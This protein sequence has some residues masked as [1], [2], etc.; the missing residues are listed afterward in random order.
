M[1]LGGQPPFFLCL[2]PFSQL[3]A[4]RRDPVFHFRNWAGQGC[5]GVQTASLICGIG[6]LALAAL[7]ATQK[8]SFVDHE[9]GPVKFFH[10]KSVDEAKNG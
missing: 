10:K 5:A 8:Q 6:E 7:A 9:W 4:E 1:F 2:C 3:F